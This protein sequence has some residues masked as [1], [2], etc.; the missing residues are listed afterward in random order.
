MLER[1]GWDL[2]GHK[3]KGVSRGDG[4]KEQ[5]DDFKKKVTTIRA[6]QKTR[7]NQIA[8]NQRAECGQMK[9]A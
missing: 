9:F 7:H 4:C 6:N 8:Y 3:K 2:S 5:R 1:V